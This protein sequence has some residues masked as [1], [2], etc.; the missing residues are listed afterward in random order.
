MEGGKNNDMMKAESSE[1]DTSVDLVVYVLPT[2]FFSVL[3]HLYTLA[4]RFSHC[5]KPYITFS[6]D[7]NASRMT[8]DVGE[9]KGFSKAFFSKA[10]KKGGR[11]VGVTLK[12]GSTGEPF[13]QRLAAKVS[14]EWTEI[15]ILYVLQSSRTQFPWVFLDEVLF[16]PTRLPRPTGS[17]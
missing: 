5:H 6:W 1:A 8:I 14:L 15:N 9:K 10:S 12:L 11:E 13:Q 17:K 7:L 16:F 4:S 3:M 2:T